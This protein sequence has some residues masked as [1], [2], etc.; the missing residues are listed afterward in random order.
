MG[1]HMPRP[2]VLVLISIA[3]E[4]LQVCFASD[5]ELDATPLDLHHAA[6]NEHALNA[7]LS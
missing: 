2:T 5:V 7:A 6:G 1:W 3:T 4:N